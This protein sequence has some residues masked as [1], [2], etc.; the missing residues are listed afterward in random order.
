MATPIRKTHFLVSIIAALIN[1]VKGA[2]YG[3]PT[4]HSGQVTFAAPVA[5]DLVSIVADVLL[6]NGAQTIA[7]QPAAPCKLRVRITDG[8][9]SI[10]AG[11]LTL[12]GVN[13][14]GQ[15]VTQVINLAGGTRTVVTND[16]YA[17]LTSATVA[18]L[19]GNAAGDNVGIGQS[20]ALGLPLPPSGVSGIGV[21]RAEFDGAPETGGT[22]DSA[23]GTYTPAG[24][25]DGTKPVT[26]WFNYSTGVGGTDPQVHLDRDERLITTAD[27]SSLSTSRALLKS[28]LVAVYAHFPDTLHHLAADTAN[29]PGDPL[30]DMLSGAEAAT[31]GDLQDVANEIKA[32]FNAHLT[33]SGVHASSGSIDA[34]STSDASDQTTLNALLNALKAA[35][36]A[37]FARGPEAASVRAVDL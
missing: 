33:Q 21:F 17:V 7:A 35:F 16:A 20:A 32:S 19:A 22:V 3:A 27:A 34:V 2:L 25:P 14:R 31:L 36:N 12:V 5:P 9:S 13:A 18:G 11:T 6:A 28:L 10:S 15:A 24:S 37:H 29:M 23:A 8:D 1:G 26:V 4:Q 30:A